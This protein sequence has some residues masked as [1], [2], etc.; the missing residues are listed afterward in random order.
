LKPIHILL[1]DDQPLVRVGLRSFL[2]TVNE[3]FVIHEAADG[4]E[5]LEIFYKHRIDLLILDHR[6]P[7]MSGYEVAREILSVNVTKKIIIVSMF[8][9]APLISRLFQLG[10][11]GFISKN[12]D[13]SEL[14][15]AIETVLAGKL[16]FSKEFESILAEKQ[17]TLPAI[18]FTDRELDL[19]IS[20]SKG[21]TSIEISKN[22]GISVKTVETY[23]SRLIEKTG[24]KNIAELIH[25]FHRNGQL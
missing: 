15:H 9:D 25:Y 11:N 17:S 21:K 8:T 14:Q 16:Y 2:K 7:R 22:W 23:R 10:V 5:T 18:S 1:A 20:L 19:V 6:M 13:V 24:V 12:A 4:K 3:N